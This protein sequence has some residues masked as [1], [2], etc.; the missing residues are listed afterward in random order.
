MKVQPK[1]RR[2][3]RARSAEIKWGGLGA[4]GSPHCRTGVL[5]R[6]WYLLDGQENPHASGTMG[7]PWA[8]AKHHW[9]GY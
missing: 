5:A 4:P 2:R 8:D 6:L 9:A 7:V 1:V 3:A